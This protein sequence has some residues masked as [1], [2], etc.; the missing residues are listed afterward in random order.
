MFNVQLERRAPGLHNF[1]PP[2]E[3]VAGLHNFK[4]P[5]EL[6]PGFGMNA[7]GSIGEAT[8]APFPYA[9]FA[10]GLYNGL[11]SAPAL[12]PGAAQPA[13]AGAATGGYSAED[14]APGALP[15]SNG[16]R[17][18]A[19][20]LVGRVGPQCVYQCSPGEWVSTSLY[21]S[22]PCPPFIAP[23]YGTSPWG[24]RP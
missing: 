17:P 20:P 1:K 18:E 23:G 2:Q 5:E 10:R 9:A 6:A 13:F 21:P 22:G 16:P 4:P 24:G 12:D 14:A 11:G 8:A 3:L 7:D 15:A 19:C